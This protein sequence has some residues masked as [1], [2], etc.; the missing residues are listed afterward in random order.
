MNTQAIL[1]A[2]YSGHIGVLA[3][4]VYYEGEGDLSK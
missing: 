1:N 2:L 4:D 3:M